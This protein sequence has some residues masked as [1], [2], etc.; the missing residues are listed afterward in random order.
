LLI[1]VY[2]C[3]AMANADCSTCVGLQHVATLS[4]FNCRWCDNGC[5]SQATC[6]GS[7]QNTCPPPRI[8][9]VCCFQH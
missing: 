6:A 4:K 8:N 3:T 7:P 9:K 1:A 5:Q 2:N